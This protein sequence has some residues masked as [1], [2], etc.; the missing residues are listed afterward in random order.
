V[1]LSGL[2]TAPSTAKIA[3]CDWSAVSEREGASYGGNTG[4]IFGEIALP[5][6][7]GRSAVEPF[8][9]LAYVGVDT[10]GFTES[11]GAAALMID[12]FVLIPHISAAWQH[13]FDDVT[14]D[15]GLAFASFEAGFTVSGVPI[16]QDAALI[17]AGIMLRF[18]DDASFGVFYQ[19]QLASDVEDHGLTGR[20]DWQF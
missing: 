15:A 17:E 18:A 13:A 3:S 14:V 4:Q 19:G 5:L 9:G 2:L 16:A 12:G 6:I 1:G 20:L 7:A 11:G 8:A 10:N